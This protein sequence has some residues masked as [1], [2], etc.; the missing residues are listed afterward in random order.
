[1]SIHSWNLFKDGRVTF[2][3]KKKTSMMAIQQPPPEAVVVV[4]AA[5]DASQKI[6]IDS[7]SSIINI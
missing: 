7:F 6:V 3:G 2:N 4:V 1:M 5:A